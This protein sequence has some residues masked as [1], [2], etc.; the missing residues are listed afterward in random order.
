MPTKYGFNELGHERA[1]IYCKT[2]GGAWE[3]PEERQAEHY[4]THSKEVAETKKSAHKKETRMMVLNCRL[5]GKTFEQER[6]HGRPK[7]DCE[8]CKKIIEENGGHNW[9]Y[10]YLKERESVPVNVDPNLLEKG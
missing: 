7:K 3:W 9:L 10:K 2:R 8:P 5:C 4:L 6:K 1:C